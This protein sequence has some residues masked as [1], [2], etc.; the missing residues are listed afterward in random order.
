MAI[1]HNTVVESTWKKLLQIGGVAVSC[2]DCTAG[3]EPVTFS[4]IRST[5]Q[6]FVLIPTI[7]EMRF[8]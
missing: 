5:A 7:L 4:Q 2:E 3:G 1:E 6:Y 8:F